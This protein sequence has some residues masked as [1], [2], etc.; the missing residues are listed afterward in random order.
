MDAAMSDREKGAP[1]TRRYWSVWHVAAVLIGFVVAVVVF[2]Y[3]GD[4]DVVLALGSGAGIALAGWVLA[5]LHLRQ[6]RDL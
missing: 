1:A 5:Y 4:S 2:R 6:P 3:T